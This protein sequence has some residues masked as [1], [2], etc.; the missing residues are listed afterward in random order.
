MKV[1]GTPG[2]HQ[3]KGPEGMFGHGCSIKSFGNAEAFNHYIKALRD[4]GRVVVFHTPF[5]AEVQA[6]S[7]VKA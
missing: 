6:S 1:C 4:L 5:I 7:E 2:R 3:V